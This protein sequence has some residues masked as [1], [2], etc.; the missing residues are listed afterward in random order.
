MVQAGDM[1]A[2]ALVC[3]MWLVLQ[4]VWSG[5]GAERRGYV[6]VTELIITAAATAAAAA[7]AT[8]TATATT[9]AAAALSVDAAFV[10]G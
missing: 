7:A 10:H 8:A 4:V 1:V 9:A 5:C 2:C 3:G 6:V